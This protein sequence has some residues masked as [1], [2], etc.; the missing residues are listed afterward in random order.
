MVARMCFCHA[1]KENAQVCEVSH[2]LT[3]TKT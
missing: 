2:R 3:I 1:S